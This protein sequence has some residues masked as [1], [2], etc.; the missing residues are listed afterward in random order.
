M[1]AAT[2][3]A[4]PDRLERRSGTCPCQ[5]SCSWAASLSLIID[6]LRRF[7]QISFIFINLRNFPHAG[8]PL[9]RK[10]FTGHYRFMVTCHTVT[11]FTEILGIGCYEEGAET[12]SQSETA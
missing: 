4:L 6:T 8:L 5:T 3:R 2:A 7:V 10:I 9:L 12:E 11:L 1:L